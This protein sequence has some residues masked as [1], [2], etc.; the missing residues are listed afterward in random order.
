[1]ILHRNELNYYDIFLSTL[2]YKKS[3][4]WF[5]A[6]FSDSFSVIIT[7]ISEFWWVFLALSWSWFIW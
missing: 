5:L 6:V 1:M 4:C 2:D 7:C 3:T